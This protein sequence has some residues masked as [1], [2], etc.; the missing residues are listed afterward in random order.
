[1]DRYS[2]VAFRIYCY[3][4][5]IAAR[6][7]LPQEA[8]FIWWFRFNYSLSSTIWNQCSWRKNPCLHQWNRSS[9]ASL[10]KKKRPRSSL[11]ASAVRI[12]STTKWSPSVGWDCR[13]YGPDDPWESNAMCDFKGRNSAVI[14]LGNSMC[15]V[16]VGGEPELGNREGLM[17][18]NSAKKRNTEL[19]HNIED[20]NVN[21]PTSK[22][23]TNS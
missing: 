22:S 9:E 13:V 8:G 12:G 2:S 23:S 20:I 11:R 15:I 10:E 14:L 16:F 1:M 18:H 3:R 4:N 6:N 19:Q 5:I 7:K 17:K 21:A